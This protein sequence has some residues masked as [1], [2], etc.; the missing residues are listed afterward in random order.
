MRASEKSVASANV[1]LDAQASALHA[2]AL[3]TRSVLFGVAA[4]VRAGYVSTEIA[5]R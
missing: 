5:E 1:I 3:T 4:K 2:I